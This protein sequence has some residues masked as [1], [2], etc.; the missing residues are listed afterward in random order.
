MEKNHER[1]SHKFFHN[2]FLK[3]YPDTMDV[4]HLI[5]TV[6]TKPG[7]KWS[8]SPM[9]IIQRATILA[10]TLQ[11]VHQHK[12]SEETAIPKILEKL[13]C[14][15]KLL[16]HYSDPYEQKFIRETL[17]H[18]SVSRDMFLECNLW[19][20]VRHLSKIHHPSS[21]NVEVT[22]P[23][24]AA[25]ALQ[26]FDGLDSSVRCAVASTFTEGYNSMPSLTAVVN[27]AQV[28]LEASAPSHE[29]CTWTS[30]FNQVVIWTLA[31]DKFHNCFYNRHIEG[32]I[33]SLSQLLH[34]ELKSLC[35]WMLS[36]NGLSIFCHRR[37]LLTLWESVAATKDITD[38]IPLPDATEILHLLRH[39]RNLIAFGN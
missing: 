30:F 39:T 18:I 37:P 7:V 38:I 15:L 16:H 28:I 23:D 27:L 29:P 1:E 25:W 34:I 3:H 33:A 26:Y 24:R 35:H 5:N 2:L 14:F 8:D 21:V 17:D 31:L 19:T 11:V 32:S 4:I 20:L 13:K 10:K 36:V 6:P 12:L 9:C 22:H